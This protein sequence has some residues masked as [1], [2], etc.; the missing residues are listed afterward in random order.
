MTEKQNPDTFNPIRTRRRIGDVIE[1]ARIKEIE[2]LIREFNAGSSKH[3]TAHDLAKHI[4]RMMNNHVTAA[5]LEAA[6]GE[7][8][9]D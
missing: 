4:Y 1:T 6:L 2:T 5:N 8:T 3:R 9:N 7:T